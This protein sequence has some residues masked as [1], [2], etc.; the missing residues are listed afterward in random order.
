MAEQGEDFSTL[1]DMVTEAQQYGAQASF[2]KPSLDADSL[3][4]IITSLASSLTT[5]KTEMTELNTGKA[6][7]LRMDIKREKLNTPDS[8]GNWTQYTNNYDGNTNY[9]N[10]IWSWNTRHRNGFV[11][12]I[13]T[14]CGNCFEE[15]AKNECPSCRSYSLCTYC[16]CF[17]D[18]GFRV[19]QSRYNN[20]RS[21][22]S[23]LL[24]NKR[25]GHIVSKE[26]P[27]FSIAVKEQYFGEGAERLVRKVR[28]LD[29]NGNFQGPVMVAKES[30]F[31]GEYYPLNLH[32]PHLLF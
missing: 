29:A 17:N 21:E 25:S 12:V 1:N 30:R 22:C 8:I 10:R 13:D 14:R 31:I 6:K 9:V 2:G 20:H 24:S 7:L 19:H 18:P 15:N 3:S 28:H 16:F 11:E 4:N 27:S 26:L 5:S 32:N 23:V